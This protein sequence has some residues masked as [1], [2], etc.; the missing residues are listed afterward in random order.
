MNPFSSRAW[1]LLFSW[2]LA[3]GLVFGT[4]LW[5]A[6]LLCTRVLLEQFWQV[7]IAMF[8][9]LA[10]ISLPQ[11]VI[12]FNQNMSAWWWSPV[13]LLGWSLLAVLGLFHEGTVLALLGRNELFE[14]CEVPEL[15]VPMF[16][17][18]A[19]GGMQLLGCPVIRNKPWIWVVATA[20]AFAAVIL[21]LQFQREYS[22]K[23]HL[24]NYIIG[25]LAGASYGMITG[26]AILYLRSVRREPLHSPDAGKLS[27]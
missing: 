25:L 5:F 17:G 27:H 1:Q 19:F 24:A 12:L 20:V 23:N 8:V 16:Y 15:L 13:S 26:V 7:R 6:N 14:S 21:V 18:S 9:G 3:S 2:A 11:Q 10:A 22:V 4:T